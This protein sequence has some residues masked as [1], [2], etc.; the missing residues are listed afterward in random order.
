LTTFV[1]AA[2]AW[3]LLAFALA[4]GSLKSALVVGL[5]LA[6]GRALPVA[7]LAPLGER[8]VAAISE[9]PAS[10]RLVRG[11]AAVSLA[12][13]VAAVFAGG[14][15]AAS[16]VP[17]PAGDP[18]VSTADLAWEQPGIGGFLRVGDQTVQLPGQDP[19]IGG[20]LVAW[21]VGDLVTVATRATL[22]P[23]FQ[24]TIV[25][26]RRLAISDRWVAFTAVDAR[27]AMQ[28]T[29]QSLA[30][31]SRTETVALS[32]APAQVGRPS[33]DGDR[34]AFHVA[35]RRSSWISVVD[36]AAG[37]RSRVRSSTTSQLLNPALEGDKL[38]Y[39]RAGRCAQE[40]RLGSLSGPGS[41]R[42]LLTLP[43]LAGADVG[44]DAHHPKQGT[45]VPCRVPPRKTARMLWTTAL[46]T[47]AAYVTILQPQARGRTTP[48]L[49]EVPR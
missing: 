7:V 13:A 18:S 33:L 49:L 4:L 47:G 35:T 22:V 34:L 6:V 45:H 27:G 9:R 48:T 21:H 25:G 14:A 44:H 19:A 12:T 2:A 32:A 36:L 10:L 38:L 17:G 20:A 30:D 41:D 37:T 5:C 16:V 43:P 42:V 24:E 11:L 1:P 15:G 8:A 40:L 28:L 23:V 26:V 31:T 3:A 39:V 29:A 46:A